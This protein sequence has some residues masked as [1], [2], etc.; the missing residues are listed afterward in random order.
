MDITKILLTLVI[1]TAGGLVGYKLKIPAGAM[2]GSLGAVALFNLFY[3]SLGKMPDGVMI[4]VQ[5]VLGS[6]LGLSFTK[7]ML[8][9]LKTAWLPA[10]IIAG[11]YLLAG[12][13]VGLFVAKVTGWDLMTSMFSAVPGGLADVVAASQSIDGV[14]TVNVMVIHSVRLA[15]VLLSIPILVKVFGK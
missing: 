7:G 1:G 12:V 4:A 13:L 11:T 10:L 15:M 2:I 9:D 8:T 5:I 14:K 3:G 6:A